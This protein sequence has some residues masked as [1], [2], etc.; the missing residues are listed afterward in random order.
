MV[1][2]WLRKLK[3][4]LGKSLFRYNRALRHNNKIKERKLKSKI[5]YDDRPCNRV[6]QNNAI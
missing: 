3:K 6:V 1:D 4:Y 5:H 2:F